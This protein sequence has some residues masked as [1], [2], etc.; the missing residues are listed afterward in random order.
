MQ[1]HNFGDSAF[2]IAKEKDRNMLLFLKRKAT[3]TGLIGSEL[4]GVLQPTD[5]NP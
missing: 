4:F 1:S 2:R 5:T 3:S